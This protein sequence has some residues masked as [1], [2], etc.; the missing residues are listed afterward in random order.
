MA[1]PD[2]TFLEAGTPIAWT[3]S[4]GDRTLT[5]TSLSNDAAR[6]GQKSLT[7]VDGT[8]GMPEV[9]EIFF[10][11]K[12]ASAGT[13]GAPI[14]IYFAESSSTTAATDNPG[15]I[16]GSDGA[17]STPGEYK[18][19]LNPVGAMIVSNAAGTGAQKQRF[20]YAPTCITVTPVVVNRSGQALSST[21]GD[22]VLRVTPY[23]RK[24]AE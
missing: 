20:T 24:I 11:T 19:Q 23:Y 4:G 22:H 15:S 5:L 16:T 12:L 18:L 6:Q 9:L 3:A 8:R 7:L 13:N 14:E 1:L 21:A 2:Y 10:E 17:L